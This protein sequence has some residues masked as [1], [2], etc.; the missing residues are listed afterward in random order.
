MPAELVAATVKVYAMPFVRP[1]TVQLVAPVV[2]Q[3]RTGVPKSED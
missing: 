2:V 3:V 1:V